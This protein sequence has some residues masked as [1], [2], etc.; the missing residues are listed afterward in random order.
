MDKFDREFIMELFLD[1]DSVTTMNRLI[2]A[3]TDVVKENNEN[4]SAFKD[5]FK[6][7]WLPQKTKQK[8]SKEPAEPRRN[9]PRNRQKW[10]CK[11]EDTLS[12]YS[13]EEFEERFGMKKHTFQVLNAIIYLCNK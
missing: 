2:V 7:E 11:N 4:V 5:I 1:N 13:E 12:Q 9:P 8:E 3:T 6:N 10:K